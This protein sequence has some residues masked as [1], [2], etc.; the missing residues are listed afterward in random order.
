MAARRRHAA[1]DEG[2]HENV[3]RWLLTYADMITLLMVLFIVLFSIGQLDIKKFEELRQGL[4]QSFGTPTPSLNDSA[5]AEGVLDG[6]VLP[7]GEGKDDPQMTSTVSYAEYRAAQQ[8]AATEQAALRQT[9]NQISGTL[10]GQGL[11]DQVVFHLESRGLVLQIVSDQV[12][13]DTGKADLLPAGQS[14]LDGIATAIAE[15]PNKIMIEGHTDDR[16]LNGGRPYAT[17]WELST[18]RATSVLRYFTEVKGIPANRVSAAGY[19][20]QKPLVP[21]DSDVNRAKNRR[22]EI[23]VL[24]T[25]AE[26]EQRLRDAAAAAEEGSP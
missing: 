7:N 6:G 13:F 25:T 14:V 19:A 8:A 12:L 16:P 11:G 18:G 20:D 26:S 5:G 17:N 2:A 4:N 9:E 24:A 23:V 15:L 3:E 1:E 22:V 21:N 10:A